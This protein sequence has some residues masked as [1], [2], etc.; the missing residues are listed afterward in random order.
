MAD[1]LP[2]EKAKEIYL[3]GF[4]TTKDKL[5]AMLYAEKFIAEIIKTTAEQEYW[6]EVKNELHNL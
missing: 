1:L 5:K 3:E 2:I 4:R 6:Q